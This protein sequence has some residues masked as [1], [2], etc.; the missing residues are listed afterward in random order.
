M[1]KTLERIRK[2]YSFSENDLKHE[3]TLAKNL[4][5]KGVEA[6]YIARTFFFMYSYSLLKK[7][8]LIVIGSC[9]SSRH[10]LFMRQK[11]QK[12]EISE[13]NSQKFHDQ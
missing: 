3:M 4:L 6:A 11:F 7:L 2:S 1:I 8:R 10:E 5:Q 12:N 9:N 13:N